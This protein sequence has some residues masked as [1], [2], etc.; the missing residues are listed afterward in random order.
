MTLIFILR[1]PSYIC[2]IIE[3]FWVINQLCRSVICDGLHLHHH[4]TLQ[5]FLISK[6]EQ[7]NIRETK[8]DYFIPHILSC[9]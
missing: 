5:N 1:S 4:V 2:I 7:F 6:L 9:L 8:P 3:F